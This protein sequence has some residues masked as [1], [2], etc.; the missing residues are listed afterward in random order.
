MRTR[1]PGMA[2]GAVSALVLAGCPSWFVP[3]EPDYATDYAGQ[4][5]VA[6]INATSLPVCVVYIWPAGATSFGT[7]W[8]GDTEIVQPGTRRD[9][10]VLPGTYGFRLEGCDGSML[11]YQ[12]SADFL[13]PRELF[14]SDGTVPVY[15]PAAGYQRLE[16]GV[17]RAPAPT[18][19]Y[20]STGGYGNTSSGGY[21]S[22]SG[23]YGSTSS[24]GYGSTSS[25][26]SYGSTSSGGASNYFSLTL[27]N[28]CP[29]TVDLFIGDGT[30]PFGSGTYTNIGS[31]TTQSESGTLPETIWIVDESRN[32]IS[33]F[34]P[35]A[36]SSSV[37]ILESCSGFAP[38]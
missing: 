5:P 23:G 9:F 31:N 26:G 4:N 28:S 34:S 37:Q 3:A 27:H 18:Y 21:G 30:P 38:Y 24:G 17:M 15:A 16:Y 29:D 13:G 36:G 10:G 22:T 20:G 6:L 12:P 7:D 19:N 11:Q 8:L 35:S 33:S 2:I 14:L 25:G 1:I 32:P